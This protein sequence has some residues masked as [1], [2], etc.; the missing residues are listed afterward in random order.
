MKF[1]PLA[2]LG[3]TAWGTAQTQFEKHLHRDGPSVRRNPYIVRR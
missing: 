3:G 2:W 1:C